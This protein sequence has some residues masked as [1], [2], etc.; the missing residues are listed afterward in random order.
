M[1][2][3]WLITG[4]FPRLGQSARRGGAGRRA[5]ARRHGA[6]PDDV[7]ERY[8]DRIRAVALNVTMNVQPTMPFSRLSTASDDMI[9]KTCFRDPI[10][11]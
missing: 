10:R 6:Q 2:K 7:V 3:V 5:S 4:S 8:G 11:I 1:S 9:K